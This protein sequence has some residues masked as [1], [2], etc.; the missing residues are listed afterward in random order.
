MII[1]FA[2]RY[3]LPGPN[4]RRAYSRLTAFVTGFSAA[5]RGLLS[6][7]DLE[8]WWGFHE[9]NRFG[10]SV[11]RDD[12]VGFR[13][14]YAPESRQSA[15]PGAIRSLGYRVRRRRHERLHFP[16]SHPVQSSALRH[17]LFPA[18]L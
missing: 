8:M 17:R 13:G 10:S 9:K 14:R 12:W 6:R 2:S 11:T 15:A 4:C 3:G 5:L 7:S 18:S 16:R 1:F